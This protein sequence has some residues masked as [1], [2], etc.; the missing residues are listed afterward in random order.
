M[1]TDN[2]W[3]DSASA[4]CNGLVAKIESGLIRDEVNV[5]MFRIYISRALVGFLCLTQQLYLS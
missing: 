5:K 3:V 2:K 4:M 1:K